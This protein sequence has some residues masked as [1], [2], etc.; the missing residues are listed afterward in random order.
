MKVDYT[1]AENSNVSGFKVVVQCSRV[2]F[3]KR[4]H[5]CVS[6]GLGQVVVA[7]W[8][9]PCGAF[10]HFLCDCNAR[11]N[12]EGLLHGGFSPGL[13]FKYQSRY[14]YQNDNKLR[15]IKEIHHYELKIVGHQ[16]RNVNGTVCERPTIKLELVPKD[17]KNDVSLIYIY[18]YILRYIFRSVN[19]DS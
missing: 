6:P 3:G 18:T 2:G 13:S 1:G 10:L 11:A 15:I 14:T 16:K 7:H 17:T 8:K 19:E 5:L 12:G 9:K 4:G